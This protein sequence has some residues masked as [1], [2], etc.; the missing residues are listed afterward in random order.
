VSNSSTRRKRPFRLVRAL[1]IERL[2]QHGVEARAVRARRHALE[3]AGAAR[4]EGHG[5]RRARRHLQRE[6]VGAADG[7]PVHARFA[8]VRDAPFGVGADEVGAELVA[9][10]EAVAHRLDALDVEVGAR[11]EPARRGVG[12]DVEGITRFGSLRNTVRSTA[13]APLRQSGRTRWNT[14]SESELLRRL[15]K[16]LSVSTQ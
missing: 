16:P 6:V 13:T 8:E 7:A 9:E 12:D 1:P 10:P 15:P 2:L 11:Q 5:R 4:L 3:A 14:S